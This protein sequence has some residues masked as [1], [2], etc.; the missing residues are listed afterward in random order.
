M[1]LYVYVAIKYFNVSA[2]AI[3]SNKKS[4]YK[5]GELRLLESF[6]VTFLNLFLRGYKLRGHSFMTLTWRGSAPCGCPHKNQSPLTSSCLLLMP[7][8]WRF[9]TRILSLNRLK[10]GNFL[11]I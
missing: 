1:T 6:V 3:F 9:W 10:G 11:S 7:G 5:H 8:R 4:V 2:N